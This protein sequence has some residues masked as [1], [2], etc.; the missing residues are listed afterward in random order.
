MIRV[1]RFLS[2]ALLF[3]TTVAF[4]FHT[5]AS[6]MKFPPGLYCHLCGCWCCVSE[7]SVIPIQQFADIQDAADPDAIPETIPLATPIVPQDLRES[8]VPVNLLTVTPVMSKAEM[9]G[10][11]DHDQRRAS[12]KRVGPSRSSTLSPSKLNVPLV[13]SKLSWY[14]HS[15]AAD[16]IPP[17]PNTSESV[18]T[19]SEAPDRV[20]NHSFDSTTSLKTVKTVQRQSSGSSGI[21]KS[22]SKVSSSGT[23]SVGS[24]N[25]SE[26]DKTV[27]IRQS[28]RPNVAKAK[29]PK[30][31]MPKSVRRWMRH[32]APTRFEWKDPRSPPMNA[33]A[34][35]MQVPS[36]RSRSQQPLFRRLSIE[37]M[38]RPPTWK[39]RRSSSAPPQRPDI[40]YPARSAMYQLFEAMREIPFKDTG[41][42]HSDCEGIIDLIPFGRLPFRRAFWRHLAI[43]SKDQVR[44][45]LV[46]QCIDRFQELYAETLDDAKMRLRDD[47]RARIT[48][49]TRNLVVLNLENTVLNS[50]ISKPDVNGS[51]LCQYNR[52]ELVLQFIGNGKLIMMRPGLMQLLFSTMPQKIGNNVFDFV[53]YADGTKNDAI[54]NAVAIE[55]YFNWYYLMVRHPNITVKE[56]HDL[57]FKFKFIM[58]Y[59]PEQHWVQGIKKS[60]RSLNQEMGNGIQ[61]FSRVLIVDSGTDWWSQLIPTESPASIWNNVLPIKIPKFNIS[62]Q[63]RSLKDLAAQRNDDIILKYV[64]RLF[65]EIDRHFKYIM[66]ETSKFP[67]MNWIEFEGDKIRIV[68]K[69][70]RAT[71]SPMSR[72]YRFRCK[73]SRKSNPTDSSASSGR[74]A[75]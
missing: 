41:S 17:H 67:L 75:G 56:H 48:N 33:M 15:R 7:T 61:Q 62:S 57:M 31:K 26:G 65:V 52:R 16:S 50:D 13:P 46:D 11:S 68:E 2:V 37:K 60:L 25:E 5:T 70:I 49:I 54:H 10:S 66:D 47:H 14:T 72:K 3:N 59:S 6:A 55:M 12:S 44:R 29:I 27:G 43:S 58:S 39:L 73:S 42:T 36:L 30:A 38:H 74:E 40:S 51:L 28:S 9:E 24:S 4:I 21:L 71:T 64:R 22:V 20:Q 35:P 32:S 45:C 1:A 8:H 19:H 63:G 18:R 23:D 53:V 34:A 69:A